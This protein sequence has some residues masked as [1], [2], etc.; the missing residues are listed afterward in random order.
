MQLIDYFVPPGQYDSIEAQNNRRKMRLIA[1]ISF[2]SGVL[3]IILPLVSYSIVG[4]FD[5]IDPLTFTMG[6][7]MFCLPFLMKRTQ[8]ITL[9]ASIFIACI[10]AIT[11]GFSLVL[12]GASSSTLPFFLLLPVAATYFLG[13]RVGFGT[14]ILGA[15]TLI[16]FHLFRQT[17]SEWSIIPHEINSLMFTICFIV[18]CLVITLFMWIYDTYQK[19]SNEEMQRTL[20]KLQQAYNELVVARDQA[21]AA[22]KAKSEFLANMS[23]EIRTP[24]NG[25]IGMAGLLMGTD[26]DDE[27]LDYSRTI[28]GS[29]DALL[30]VINDIL[31]F[32]KVEAGKVELEEQPFDLRQCVQESL[33]LMITKADQ[34]GLALISYIPL[35]IPTQVIGDSTRLRQILINLI[36]NAIKFTQSGEI[37]ITLSYAN[38]EDGRT[39]YEFAVKD[40]GIGI[41]EDR[42]NRLF[43]SFSQVDSSTTRKFGGTGL[44]LAISQMLAELMGGEMWADSKV[45]VGSTF[46]FTVN[47]PNHSEQTLIDELIAQGASEFADKTAIV[48]SENQTQL[49][50]LC[51]HLK[52]LHINCLPAYSI[53]QLIDLCEINVP[54]DF[55]VVDLPTNSYLNRF[56]ELVVQASNINL[57]LLLFAHF[58]QK[59]NQEKML[60][61]P[62]LRLNKPIKVDQL[63]ESLKSFVHD[64]NKLTEGDLQLGEYIEYTSQ[65]SDQYPFEIL[66]ADDNRVNQK[67]GLKMLEKL[68]YSADV[69]SSGLEVIDALNRKKYDLILMDVQM[70]EMDGVEATAV[71]HEVWRDERPIIIAVTANAMQGDKERFLSAGMDAYLSKPIKI[72]GL[73]G[74]LQQLSSANSPKSDA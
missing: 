8:S 14:A 27:Q 49:D 37:T 44:G 22:T 42:M 57:P 16:I 4:Y 43:K 60:S 20:A 2:V 53:H 33:D 35:D 15:I 58:G 40:T 10:I 48:V 66:V 74:A 51:N 68:G 17:L 30:T 29:G 24:L 13:I 63:F 25:V 45:G 12:G 55:A 26:L 62:V 50:I 70:P 64:Q 72:E 3:C 11:F 7:I 32:S 67:V 18:A 54:A 38:R 23:H 56:D 61:S 9:P 39:Q 6:L 5:Q 59:V 47:Y 65:F 46:Y 31:D 28:Q 41:P 69:V 19:K 36:G 71:I 21:E 73:A 1:T 34:K 52:R